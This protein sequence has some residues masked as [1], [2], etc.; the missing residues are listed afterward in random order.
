MSAMNTPMSPGP[1]WFSYEIGWG[2]VPCRTAPAWREF[3]MHAPMS[4]RDVGPPLPPDAPP[5]DYRGEEDVEEHER[6]ERIRQRI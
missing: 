4:L 2:G 1:I 6:A 5:A 3:Q